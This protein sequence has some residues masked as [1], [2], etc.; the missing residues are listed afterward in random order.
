[1][2]LLADFFEFDPNYIYHYN[3]ET[4]YNEIVIE[5]LGEGSSDDE[6]GAF[7]NPLYASLLRYILAVSVKEESKEVWLCYALFFT[8]AY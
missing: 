8:A 6:K 1:M 5:R 2:I 7:E 3:D 4:D